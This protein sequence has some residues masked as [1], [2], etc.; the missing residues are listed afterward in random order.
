MDS[1]KFDLERFLKAQEGVYPYALQEMKNGSKETH[2]MWF[3]FPQLKSLG[4]SDTA[5]YYGIENIEE[6]KAY[7]AHPILGMRL[8]EIS[9]ALLTIENNDPLELMGYPDNLKLCSSMTLFSRATE[10]NSIFVKV[11]YKFYGGAF[12]TYTLMAVDGWK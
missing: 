6:A 2:W 11:I 7:L 3:I 8:R 4:R 12:D 5:I 9:A 10:D 1:N